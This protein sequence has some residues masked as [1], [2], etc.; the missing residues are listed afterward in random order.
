MD[1]DLSILLSVNDWDPLDLLP[2]LSI[3]GF[4]LNKKATTKKVVDIYPSTDT[5]I[6]N[7]LV[8]AL[9]T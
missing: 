9:C 7:K 8:A 3:G 1:H 2:F 6:V 4:D 5:S